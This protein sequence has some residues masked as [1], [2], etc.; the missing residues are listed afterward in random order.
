MVH[1]EESERQRCH[2]VSAR[3]PRA[4]GHC[5]QGPTE[6]ALPQSPHP[7]VHSSEHC[8]GAKGATGIVTTS[9]VSQPGS[10]VHLEPLPTAWLEQGLLVEGG[11]ARGLTA[12]RVATSL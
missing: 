9:L 12:G 3:P 2:L 7:R 6:Q 4:Q 11:P 8:S 10:E 1:G 5:R